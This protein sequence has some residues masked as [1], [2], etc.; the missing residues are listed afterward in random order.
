M[1]PF[2]TL[3][4]PVK[5]SLQATRHSLGHTPSLWLGVKAKE[6]MVYVSCNFALFFNACEA[7]LVIEMIERKYCHLSTSCAPGVALHNV[8]EKKKKK[9]G[10]VCEENGYKFIPFAFS[11]FG[12]FDMDALDTLLRIKSISISH[13]NNAKSGVFIFHR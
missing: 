11:T 1:P 4:D 13:S 12:E 9:Y 3:Q 2:N 5:A 6:K 7:E 8:V 10:S